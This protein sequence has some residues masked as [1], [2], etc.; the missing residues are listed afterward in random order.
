MASAHDISTDVRRALERLAEI[1]DRAAPVVFAG[2]AAEFALLES[3]VRGVQRGENGRTVVVQGVPGV[4]KTAL[5]DEFAARLLAHDAND[6]KAVIPV[7]LNASSLGFKPGAIVEQIDRAFRALASSDWWQRAM[8]RAAAGAHFLG[9]ALFAAA[10]RKD[11][12]DFTAASRAPDSLGV[13]LDD[14]VSQRLGRRGSTIVLLVDEAQNLQDTSTV[15]THLEELHNDGA[16]E[17][18]M[19]LACFGL[20][21]TVDRL[22]ELGLSRLAR[23][24]VRSIGVLSNE[25]ARQAVVGTLEDVLAGHTFKGRE[26]SKWISDA[27]NVILEDSGNFPHHLTNGCSALAQAVLLDGIDA[28]PPVNGVRERARGYRQEYYEARLRPWSRYETALAYAF[29][30]S[31][32]GR[33]PT[34]AV[35]AGLATVTDRGRAVSEEVAWDVVEGICSAGFME[36]QDDSLSVLLPSLMTHFQDVCQRRSPNPQMVHAIRAQLPARG[37]R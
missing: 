27:A 14:Y 10:T 34:K 22:A 5:R 32:D 31:S 28:A 21:N 11:I 7:Q 9:N 4:G 33:T 23:G 15:R 16:G 13:V 20:G 1:G 25:E 8:G 19:M 36:E 24:H 26:R 17:T 6:G 29:T 35:V 18:P 30:E 2:R 3:A 12:G 37:Q